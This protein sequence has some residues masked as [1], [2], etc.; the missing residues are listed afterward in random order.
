[1]HPSTFKPRVA[2]TLEYLMIGNDIFRFSFILLIILFISSQSLAQN[3]TCTDPDLPNA[4]PIQPG[5]GAFG[6]K[7]TYQCDQ[8]YSASNQYGETQFTSDACE[9]D[10]DYT[11]N[12]SPFSCVAIKCYDPQPA[13]AH[14]VTPVT[15]A[16]D[17]MVK[18]QCNS[19]YQ[20]PSGSPSSVYTSDPC[21]K[22]GPY[23]FWNN[24]GFTC[25]VWNTSPSGTTN[26]SAAIV[27]PI[28]MISIISVAIYC[29]IKHRRNVQLQV[30]PSTRAHVKPLT[31]VG[32]QLMGITVVGKVQKQQQQ[33]Q[34]QQP[35]PTSPLPPLSAQFSKLPT[36]PSFGKQPSTP[37]A[38]PPLVG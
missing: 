8:G 20:D 23:T 16:Y 2:Q 24:L 27:V 36:S 38:V 33:Q 11:F 37:P 22:N 21:I 30:K 32:V 19:G 29:F 15:G 14:N 5:T 13:N 35:Q 28:I 7:V 25:Q 18:Y 26:I 17:S 12:W 9:V 6:S 34:Q 10:G 31:G 1:M 3:L 4:A